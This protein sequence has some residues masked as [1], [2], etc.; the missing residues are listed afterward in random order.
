M[1][2]ALW[3]LLALLD[4]PD[5]ATVT[6]STDD[7]W[8]DELPDFLG[9]DPGDDAPAPSLMRSQ[10]SEPRGQ[11]AELAVTVVRG[12]S[13]AELVGAVAELPAL[14]HADGDAAWALSQAIV[15]ADGTAQIAAHGPLSKLM[16]RALG[17]A[18]L[19]LAVSA[20]AVAGRLH[21]ADLQNEVAAVLRDR[22]AAL[23][24]AGIELT[25]DV[26]AEIADGRCVRVMEEALMNQAGTLTE[27][28]AWRARHIVQLIRRDGRR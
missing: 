19:S 8:T 24:K 1:T 27:H 3:P 17:A 14:D 15:Q 9:G 25:L 13:L 18:D 6:A 7:L 4:V 22:G 26:L 10:P 28:Q 5:G 11:A 21:L 2:A 20:V 23:D 16:G 12:I